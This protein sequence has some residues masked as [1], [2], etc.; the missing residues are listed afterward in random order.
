MERAGVPNVLETVY[1]GIQNAATCT[2]IL[3]KYIDTLA[4][5]LNNSLF[6]L[7]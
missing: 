4:L 2:V 6:P 1:G 5:F 7:K 3:A